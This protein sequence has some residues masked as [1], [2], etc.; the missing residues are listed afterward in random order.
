VRIFEAL[1]LFLFAV[2]DLF[3]TLA[4]FSVWFFFSALLSFIIYV[5]FRR[6]A[7]SRRLA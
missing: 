1:A 5:R 2:A 7:T 6:N 3:F 4:L